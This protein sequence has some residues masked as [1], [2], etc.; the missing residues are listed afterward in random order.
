MQQPSNGGMRAGVGWNPN[1]E[2][3]IWMALPASCFIEIDGDPQPGGWLTPGM[4][5]ELAFVLLVQAEQISNGFTP[6]PLDKRPTP[7]YPAAQ[8]EPSAPE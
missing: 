1:G 7:A 4:A 2:V 6:P 8:D 3:G 5:R